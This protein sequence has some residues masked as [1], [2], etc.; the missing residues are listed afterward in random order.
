MNY[1]PYC[2]KTHLV[3]FKERPNCHSES[4][5]SLEGRWL[6]DKSGEYWQFSYNVFSALE[7]SAVAWLVSLCAFRL[8]RFEPYTEEVQLKEATTVILETIEFTGKITG[9]VPF[10]IKTF[11]CFPIWWPILIFVIKSLIFT[12]VSNLIQ[13]FKT[14]YRGVFQKTYP[15]KSAESNK[16]DF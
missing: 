6:T 9:N 11:N 2:S 14:F 4:R 12:I 1:S 15:I 10:K 13:G 16:H 5:N 7:H 8:P 3:T